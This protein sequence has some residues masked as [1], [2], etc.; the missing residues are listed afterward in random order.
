[1]N[2]Q[3]TDG[4]VGSENA[5]YITTVDTRHPHLSRLTGCTTPRVSPH[6]NG[7]L[8]VTVLCQQ[9]VTN[10]GNVPPCRGALM[11]K[12]AVHVWGQEH[13]GDLCTVFTILLQT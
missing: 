10:C 13:S 5:L 4:F 8:W 6:V 9:T 12:E 11:M 1:M 3:R 2:R 7:G